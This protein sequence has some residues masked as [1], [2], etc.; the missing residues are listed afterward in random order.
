MKTKR[1]FADNLASNTEFDAYDRPYFSVGSDERVTFDGYDGEPAITWNDMRAVDF[2]TRF[3]G[4]GTY[5]IFDPHPAVEAEQAKHS[6][7][8]LTNAVSIINGVQPYDEL[9]RALAGIYTDKHGIRHQVEGD[10]QVWRR[11]S[12]IICIESDQ[13]DVSVNRGFVDLESYTVQQIMLEKKIA[14][15][16]K[17]ILVQSRKS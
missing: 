8:I 6:R 5:R 15:S 1:A 3:G 14:G 9:I 17:E 10:T 12:L 11:F 2:I 16:I 4:T 13:L 7:V